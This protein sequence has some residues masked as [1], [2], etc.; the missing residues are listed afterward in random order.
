M[1]SI[2]ATFFL[3]AF[4][5]SFTVAQDSL[6][7]PITSFNP[8]DFDDDADGNKWQRLTLPKKTGPNIP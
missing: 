3:V 1:R 5:S 4:L 8:A 2:I 7:I 6:V